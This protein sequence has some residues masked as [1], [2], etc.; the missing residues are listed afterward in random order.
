MALASVERLTATRSELAKF[1]EGR[2]G[3]LLFAY[4]DNAHRTVRIRLVSPENGV[5]AEVFFGL[6]SG[7]FN[8]ALFPP[9]ERARN[10]EQL[11]GRSI[12]VESEFD[13]L[14]LQSFEVWSEALEGSR[15]CHFLAN[16]NGPGDSHR[17]VTRL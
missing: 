13:V 15:G 7:V 2:A 11:Q 16:R 17:A 5:S 4:T 6:T 12:V 10:L 3:W 9:H 14:Q 8:H 1:F